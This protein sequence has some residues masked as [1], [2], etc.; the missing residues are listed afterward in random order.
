MIDYALNHQIDA[1]EKLTGNWVKFRDFYKIGM[2]NERKA[3]PEEELEFLECK[4]SI[5]ML[6]DDFMAA[7][8]PANSVASRKK[9]NDGKSI[10]QNVIKCVTI[11]HVTTFYETDHRSFEKAWDASYL[12]LNDTLD[13]L[14]HKRETLN[15]M[16]QSEYAMNNFKASVK[17]NFNKFL[18]SP[19]P[20]VIGAVLLIVGG[21]SGLQYFKIIDLQEIPNRMPQTAKLYGKA[22][23][24]F[25]MSIMPNLRYTSFRSHMVKEDMAKTN[26]YRMQD[27]QADTQQLSN[28]LDAFNQLV[29]RTTPD[30]SPVRFGDK[31]RTMMLSMTNQQ[32]FEYQKIDV[33]NPGGNDVANTIHLYKFLLESV[34][35]TED[36]IREY[37]Q[38]PPG[39]RASFERNRRVYTHLNLLI[40]AELERVNSADEIFNDIEREFN[41]RR[42]N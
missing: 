25:R 5:A 22:E 39:N 16:S 30:G 26:Q 15:N 24:V 20:R 6:H 38:A 31:I 2:A 27:P 7:L 33:R 11:K 14:G 3:T 32:G 35:R 18:K 4:K 10:L 12:L 36:F 13:K 29:L 37:T 42:I 17:A 1:I 9:H 41:V 19:I 21:V 23:N 40:V 28:H 8:P 34:D